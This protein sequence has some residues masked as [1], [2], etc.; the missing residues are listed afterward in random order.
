MLTSI[1][2]ACSACSAPAAVYSL[3]LKGAHLSTTGPDHRRIWLPGLNVTLLGMSLTMSLMKTRNKVGMKTPPRGT[4]SFSVFFGYKFHSRG[5]GLSVLGDPLVHTPRYTI[6]LEFKSG[7]IFPDPVICLLHGYP[8]RQSM[9]FIL[10]AV[11][12]LLGNVGHL[13]F[14]RMVLPKACLLW[15]DDVV[16]L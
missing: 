9:L 12:D 5:L 13:V 3:P 4:P 10:K 16:L 15:S 6:F 1:W 14:S 8:H 7:P 11:L 2:A